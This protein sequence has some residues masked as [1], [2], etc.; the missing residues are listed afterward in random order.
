MRFDI[1]AANSAG[2]LSQRERVGVRGS[3]LSRVRAPLTPTLSPSGRGSA[4]RSWH[5]LQTLI[6]RFALG[7][8]LLMPAHARAA[9]DFY[10]GK[11]ISIVVDGGGAYEA[12][13]R[14]LA[15]YL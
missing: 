9:E 2:S 4:P 14:M 8:A 12:Y 10:A 5:R 3:G 15:Q 6:S 7:L 11:T 1:L 13:A